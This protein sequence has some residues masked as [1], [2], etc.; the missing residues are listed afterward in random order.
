MKRK[1]ESEER[2]ERERE[3]EREIKKRIDNVMK[4][5]KRYEPNQFFYKLCIHHEK[6]RSGFRWQQGAETIYLRI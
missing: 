6:Y 5:I 2:Q 3:R 4:R 1:K